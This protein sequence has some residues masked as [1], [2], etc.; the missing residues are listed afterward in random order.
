MLKNAISNTKN[1]LSSFVTKCPL[2]WSFVSQSP[3]PWSHGFALVQQPWSSPLHLLS[4]NPRCKR[5]PEHRSCHAFE[6]LR[7]LIDFKQ[8]G[9]TCGSSSQADLTHNLVLKT[10]MLRFSRHSR[11]KCHEQSFLR[12]KRAL[13]SIKDQTS[14]TS[15]YL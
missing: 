15:Q 12:Q 8:A 10:R 5:Y 14:L 7:S 4:A 6:N 9:T 13:F 3:S 2:H 11:Q 1:A